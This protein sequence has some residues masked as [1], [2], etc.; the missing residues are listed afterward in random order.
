MY[1]FSQ[2]ATPA[3][4]NYLAAQQSFLN[5]ISKSAFGTIR[6]YS[7]LNIQLAQTLLEE[8]TQ[9]GHQVLLAKRGTEQ[10]AAL[11]AHLQ[12]AVDKVR[13]YQRHLARVASGSQVDLADVS[14]QHIVETSRTAKELASEVERVTKEE[15]DKML[16]AQQYAISNFTDPFTAEADGAGSQNRAPDG[17]EVGSGVDGDSAPAKQAST[18][19]APPASKSTGARV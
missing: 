1:P 14:E 8:G 4:K 6:Q 17:H 15:T 5:A 11:A 12:P 16:R 19:S 18:S 7:D 2:D 3:L 10:F 9:T 13:A